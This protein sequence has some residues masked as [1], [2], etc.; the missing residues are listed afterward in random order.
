M[1]TALYVK[2]FEASGTAD[3][4]EDVLL[5]DYLPEIRRVVGVQASVTADGKYLSG[6]N[7]E[8]DGGVTY[9]V[10][11]TTP[12]GT[13]AHLSET[14]SYTGHIPLRTEDERYGTADIVLGASI[15]NVNCRVTAP[16]KITLSSKV[17]L[18]AF[19]QKSADVSLRV[20]NPTG[21][22]EKTVRRR[23]KNAATSCMTELRQSGETGGELREREDMRLVCASGSLCISDVRTDPGNSRAV[24]IKGDAYVTALLCAPDGT[25][26]V[27]KSRAPMEE[28][29]PLPEHTGEGEQLSPAVFGKV[30]V[31]EMEGG[32]DGCFAWKLE[33]DIDCVLVHTAEGEITADAY[34]PGQRDTLTVQEVKTCVPAAAVNGRLTTSAA[35]SLRPDCSF[36]CAWGTGTVDQAEITGTGGG[37]RLH[38]GGSVRLCAV[39]ANGEEFFLDETVIPLRYDCDALPKSGEGGQF[40][41]RIAVDVTEITARPDGNTL[42][43]TAE[44]GITAA[45]LGEE[46]HA[47]AVLLTPDPDGKLPAGRNRMTVYVPDAEESAWDVEKRFRLGR[48]AVKDGNAYVI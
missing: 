11:Y 17:K 3:V 34:L 47:A 26:T 7:L 2:R 20:E 38:L 33:Y 35:V 4:S 1:N 48:E 32:A 43:L 18:T 12:D 24:Q 45:L 29:I 30:I 23:V 5:P 9:T 46:T 42:H 39:T 44:L 41:G 8:A 14:T 28:S 10:L 36:V 27:S 40:S 22:E 13:L 25:Y 19:S 37:K 6:E 21:D 16:R 31:L 15:D